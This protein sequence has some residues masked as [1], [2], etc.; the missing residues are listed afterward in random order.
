MTGAAKLS[1]GIA[2]ALALAGGVG[3]LTSDLEQD[4]LFDIDA[5]LPFAAPVRSGPQ[6]GRPKGA[7]NKSTEAIREYLLARYRSPLVGL[8][9]LMSRSPGK[10]AEELG[11]YVVSDGMFIVDPE[12]GAK[13]LATGE[14]FRL[15]VEAMKAAL[16]Y[17]HQKLPLAIETKGDGKKGGIFVVGD[18][19]VTLGADGGLA[20]A[21]A[22]PQAIDVTPAKT[23]PD[24]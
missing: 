8:L 21:D 16:P 12:T 5:P 2:T 11:L 23:E 6:G 19:N 24:V 15:Q 18:L 13:V 1:N 4:D 17:L 22:A 7:R 20:L 3:D 9:E 14:V 10:L